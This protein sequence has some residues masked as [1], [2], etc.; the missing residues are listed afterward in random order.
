[1]TDHVSSSKLSPAHLDTHQLDSDKFND[2]C[3]V[4]GVF[5]TPE[6]ST[7]TVLGLHALQHRGQEAA[8]IVS[9]AD[10]Q[11]YS[12]KSLGHVADNFNTEPVI[13]SLPGDSAIG[14]VRYSTSGGAGLRNV[15][16]L[17]ADLARGGFAVCHNGNL[18]NALTLN[19]QLVNKGAIFQSTSDSE[20]VIHLIATS[21][22][23]SLQDKFIDAMRRVEG[24][25]AFVALSQDCLIGARDPLGV[26][27]L[28]IGKL[29]HD[30]YI[31]ASETCA[32]DIIGADFIRD[33]EP[34]EVVTVTKDGMT[35]VKPFPA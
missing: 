11:F 24:A 34:G 20:V 30:G 8:G 35:S 13:E 3:G 14:H 1:M 18:T 29:P 23:P 21:T 17:F 27:P 26:R 9:H 10:G 7:H 6:A 5:A 19:K 25:F 4:F 2:E 28:V 15:Q 32:L 16:P 33:E 22:Y 12:H 31:F